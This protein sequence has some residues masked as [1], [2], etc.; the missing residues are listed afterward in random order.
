MVVPDFEA[1]ED[2]I[3]LSPLVRS[4]DLAIVT[5]PRVTEPIAQLLQRFGVKTLRSYM[6]EPVEVNGAD[7]R[8]TAKVLVG[9]L[10]SLRSKRMARELRKRLEEIGLG[11]G[12]LKAQWR[13]RLNQI[14][15]VKIARSVTATYRIGRLRAGVVVPSAFDARTGTLWLTDVESDLEDG[16]FGAI[17]A[18]VFDDPARI[19]AIALQDAVRHE[20]R[21]RDLFGGASVESDEEEDEEDEQ[22]DENENGTGLGGAQQSHAGAQPDPKKN[23]PKPGPIPV[24]GGGRRL[25]IRHGRGKSRETSPNEKAQIQDLKKN[26]YAWHCQVCLAEKSISV[27]APEA[28]YAGI[29]ENRLRIMEAHHADQWHAGGAR[30]AGNLLILCLYHHDYLGDATSRDEITKAL[31]SRSKDHDVP[32]NT[33]QSGDRRTVRG[34][35]VTVPMPLRGASVS[36]FFTNE[37]AAYWLEKASEEA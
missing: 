25:S 19:D 30:H 10:H 31:Q 1:I 32:F 15:D 7:S 16:L 24:R 37:H 5:R 23:L 9:R 3:R 27:L 35:L 36:F 29:Q 13:D 2:R 12:K 6:G 8:Q 22:G 11:V 28:S 26:H 14:A 33:T 34:K 20:L 4:V 18:R 21:E 17:A